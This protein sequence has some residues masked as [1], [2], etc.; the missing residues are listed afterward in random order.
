MIKGPGSRSFRR[1]AG[2]I[3]CALVTAL[4]VAPAAWASDAVHRHPLGRAAQRHLHRQR[5]GLPGPQ[6]RLLEHRVLP[7]RSRP[8]RL[9]DVLQHRLRQRHPE[10]FGPDFANHAGGTNTTGNFTPHTRDAVHAR[11]PV[12][13]GIGHRGKPLSGHHRRD[14]R[15]LRA[16]AIRS[17]TSSPRST[18]TSSATTSTRPTSRS[19]TSAPAPRI[20]GARSTTPRTA[21]CGDRQRLRRRRA[22]ASA[23]Q[24]RACT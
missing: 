10:F 22:A 23:P 4:I 14:R 15:P 7:E 8:R 1:I 6:R 19:R 16:E 11:E 9:R 2:T 24:R 21:S 20:A 13:D 3:A 18:P 12:A 17:S 5:P